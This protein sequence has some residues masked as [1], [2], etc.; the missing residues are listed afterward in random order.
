MRCVLCPNN[1]KLP[2]ERITIHYKECGLDNVTLFGVERHK[3]DKCGEEYYGYGNLEKLHDL[4]ASILIKKSDLLNGK[5]VRFLRKYLGYSGA[6][7]S[8]LI[9]YDRST[10]SRIETDKQDITK[11]FDRLVRLFVKERLPDRDYDLHDHYLKKSG[12]IIER[13]ELQKH[14]DNWK[15]KRA[16]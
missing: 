9:D 12:R 5:E 7:F 1:K 4:I 15:L 3:C 6:M 2:L 11:I 10:L 16:A 14:H 8:Q 13:I